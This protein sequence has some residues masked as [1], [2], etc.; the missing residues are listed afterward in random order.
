MVGAGSPELRN[1][2]QQSRRTVVWGQLTRQIGTLVQQRHKAVS[3]VRLHLAS[4]LLLIVLAGLALVSLGTGVRK[5]V[6]SSIDFQ[7]MGSQLLAHHIDPWSIELATLPPFGDTHAPNYLHELYVMLLP[8]TRLSFHQASVVWCLLNALL[9]IAAV[10][11]VKRLYAL[12]RRTAL[13]LLLLFWAGSAFRNSIANG[14]QSLV[15]LT[16]LC[17]FYVSKLSVGKG[18]LLGLSYEKYSFTP[19]LALLQLFRGNFKLLIVSLVPPLLGFAITWYLL[20]GAPLKLAAEPLLISQTHVAAGLGDLMS[21][22]DRL[23]HRHVLYPPISALSYGAAAVCSV[24]Y[25]AR[26]ARRGFAPSIELALVCIS[27]LMIFK[28]LVYDYV[29]LLPP[30]ALALKSSSVRSKAITFVSVFMLW[31]GW[32]LLGLQ[33]HPAQPLAVHVINLCLL[34]AT[35]VT[36][37]LANKDR[38]DRTAGPQSLP[39]A[40]AG[41]EQP[42]LAQGELAIKCLPVLSRKPKGL[43]LRAHTA[44]AASR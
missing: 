34:G 36:L 3:I 2:L 13:L 41:S 1:G 28:H 35:L 23:V 33:L 21:L 29:L 6:E 31:F 37:E 12:S 38:A 39:R 10:M 40:L 42:L 8:L 25:A 18:L 30:L 15:E 14:Q 17:S 24:L 16:L 19:V 11:L 43:N 7:W 26:L 32:R 20:G 4:K 27:T 5:A 9:S 22:V 44:V